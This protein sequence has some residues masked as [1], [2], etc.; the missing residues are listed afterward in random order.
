[1][2]KKEDEVVLSAS[3]VD[4][5]L[6]LD[7]LDEEEKEDPDW[8]EYYKDEGYIELVL[9][10]LAQMCDGQFTGLQEY[11]RDQPD[12][13]KSFNLVAE[14]TSFLNMVYSNI[15]QRTIDLVIQLFC[16]LN[17]FGTGNQANR[18]VILSHKIVDYINF[19]LRAG[20]FHDCPP[21]KVLDLRQA[22]GNLL[23]SLI[24]ENGPEELAVAKVCT[25]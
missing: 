3:G 17:E 8:L 22:I 4:V 16:T 10:V 12:N 7:L 13:I 23:I 21:E 11:L 24:E 1:M 6:E 5:P 15:N 19:I 20:D 2:G 14:T 9:K 18:A 25:L